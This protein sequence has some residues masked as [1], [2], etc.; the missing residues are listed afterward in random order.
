M[1]HFYKLTVPLKPHFRVLTSGAAVETLC[2]L[3]ATKRSPQQ[4]LEIKENPRLSS[5]LESRVVTVLI[6]DCLGHQEGQ[7]GTG[8]SLL[9]VCVQGQLTLEFA[10]R[11]LQGSIRN[12]DHSLGLQKSMATRPVLHGPSMPS[13]RT[14]TF[15]PLLCL[16]PFC[17]CQPFRGQA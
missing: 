14:E 17:V 2:A 13:F 9:E 3:E 12:G 6:P 1:R 7:A 8:W 15:I 4:E 11:M 5:P 10:S 16:G